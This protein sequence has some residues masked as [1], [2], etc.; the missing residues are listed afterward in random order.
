VG[1]NQQQQPDAQ[2]LPGSP[3]KQASNDHEQQQQQLEQ[4]RQGQGVGRRL[5]SFL[6]GNRRATS[7][8]AGTAGGAGD[9][10]SPD[11]S[12]TPLAITRGVRQRSLSDGASMAQRYNAY[13]ASGLLLSSPGGSGKEKAGD[14]GGSNGPSNTAVINAA[15]AQLAAGDATA[16]APASAALPAA[17]AL[18]ED[19]CGPLTP[20]TS[21]RRSTRELLLQYFP[22]GSSKR[23]LGN[24]SHCSFGA[25]ENEAAGGGSSAQPVDGGELLK[26]TSGVSNASLGKSAGS[27]VLG[28]SKRRFIF[29]WVSWR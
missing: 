18:P 23:S 7:G 15:A 19:G 10:S 26:V 28:P 22:F 20:Q 4:Q 16:S 5:V 21:R 1:F 24:A 8:A 6:S 25:S 12:D 11:D 3:L 13:K 9:G 17:V 14:E 29:E 2:Q 27:G